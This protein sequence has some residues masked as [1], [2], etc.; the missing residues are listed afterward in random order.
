MPVVDPSPEQVMAL[1]QSSLQGPVQMINLL[2][3]R[4]DGGIESYQ[5]YTVEVQPH[6]D[7]V[8]GRVVAHSAT[9]QMVIGEDERPWWDAI[10]TVEYPSV[11]AFLQMVVSDGYQSIAHHRTRALTRAELIA[12]APGRL[13]G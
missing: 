4:P 2:Q 9:H 8:G 7:A 6:L 13:E 1:T 11:Q 12:T 10:L 5:R 3:F